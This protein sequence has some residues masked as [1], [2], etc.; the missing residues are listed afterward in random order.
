MIYKYYLKKEVRY[1]LYIKKKTHINV[2]LNLK[3]TFQENFQFNI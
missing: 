2:T 3:K 1:R